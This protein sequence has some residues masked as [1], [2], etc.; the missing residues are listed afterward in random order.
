[1]KKKIAIDIDLIRDWYPTLIKAY[2]T[3]IDDWTGDISDVEPHDL[4][5]HF[6][7]PQYKEITKEH[8]DQG[9]M[10]DGFVETV[11]VIDEDAEY[12]PNEELFN[13]FMF[14]NVLEIFGHAKETSTNVVNYLNEQNKNEE[15]NIDITL[16]S[17]AKGKAKSSTLFFL[18]KCGCEINR[19]LFVKDT[20]ELY[21][22]YWDASFV[23]K[24]S[25]VGGDIKIIDF[26]N[27]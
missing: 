7:F 14:D 22:E 8:D 18:S 9:L 4:W 15:N 1:M 13:K 17:T 25:V 16:F 10:Y 20:E 26:K 19:I 6:N 12:I 27:L 21:S 2:N 23:G 5:K 11:V 3:Q 24:K